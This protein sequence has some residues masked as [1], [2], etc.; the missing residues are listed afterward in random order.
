MP[1]LIDEVAEAQTALSTE[2]K[3][4]RAVINVF[5][6]TMA[7]LEQNLNAFKAQ[8]QIDRPDIEDEIRTFLND[9]AIAAI[10]YEAHFLNHY[11]KLLKRSRQ[12]IRSLPQ[13]QRTQRDI[14]RF[15]GDLV[16][17]GNAVDRYK[18][19]IHIFTGQCLEVLRTTQKGEFLS[20]Q[21]ILASLDAAITILMPFANAVAAKVFT[22]LKEMNDFILKAKSLIRQ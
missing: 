5:L 4:S 18:D 8:V 3:K 1:A 7:D 14:T 12:Y 21:E 20:K 11:E 16:L 10:N 17:A 15:Y 13:K 9:V 2:L 19:Q 22:Q 6:L